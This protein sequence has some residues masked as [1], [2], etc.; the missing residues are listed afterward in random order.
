MFISM[1][2]AGYQLVF[3]AP[4][5]FLEI[6]YYLSDLTQVYH[7]LLWKEDNLEPMDYR[8]LREHSNDIFLSRSLVSF[9]EYQYEQLS[10]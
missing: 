3:F 4:I 1:G 10:S 5:I 8:Y 2:F 7:I 6:L 9:A